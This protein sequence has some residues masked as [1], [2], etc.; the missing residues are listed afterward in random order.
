MRATADS[1]FGERAVQMP[2]D[3]S[4]GQEQALANFSIGEPVGRELSDLQLL[5]SESIARIRCSVADR[6]ACC[7][8]LPPRTLAPPC[9]AKSFENFD[10]SAQRRSCIR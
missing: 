7:P 10:A 9:G 5:C 8:E 3:G 4:V 2:T 1:E 6:H